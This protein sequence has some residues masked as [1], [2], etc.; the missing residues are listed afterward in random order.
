MTPTPLTLTPGRGPDGTAVLKAVGEIDMSNTDAFSAALSAALDDVPGRLV[1]DLTGCEYLDSAGI[2][3]LF[4]HAGRI[5]LVATPLLAP[6][7]TFSGLTAVTT[8]RGLED[9]AVGRGPRS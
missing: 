2:N 1:V 8:V 6:V 4:A 7:M 5:E 9:D 3:V